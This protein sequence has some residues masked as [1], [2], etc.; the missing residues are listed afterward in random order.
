MSKKKHWAMQKPVFVR[1][2]IKV[3]F[4]T[5]MLAEVILSVAIGINI[6]KR[7]TEM[8]AALTSAINESAK[9]AGIFGSTVYHNTHYGYVPSK[10]Y[11]EYKNAVGYYALNSDYATAIVEPKGNAGNPKI[12][13]DNF[14]PEVFY[15]YF[16]GSN[17]NN[18]FSVSCYRLYDDDP[19][20]LEFLNRTKGN[21]NMQCQLV[22]ESLHVFE[23][24][25]KFVPKSV[26]WLN[27]ET[28]D[29][30]A[31]YTRK[32]EIPPGYKEV[33]N[34][35]ITEI[36]M[37][38]PLNYTHEK[39]GKWYESI[40]E[41]W[42]EIQARYG[43]DAAKQLQEDIQNG[44]I[45]NRVISNG[46]L[47]LRYCAQAEDIVLVDKHGEQHE[48]RII[49][50]MQYN[51]WEIYEKS[52]VDTFVYCMMPIL[53]VSLAAAYIVYLKKW[54]LWQKNAFSRTLTNAVA[55]DLKTPLM[56]ISTMVDNLK[57]CV[58][59]EEPK[60]YTE[61][62]SDTVGYMN[63]MIEDILDLN[64]IEG[65]RPILRLEQVRLE[66][67]LAE[68]VESVQSVIREKQLSIAIQGTGLCAGDYGLLRQAFGNLV[69][70]AV[71]YTPKGGFVTIDISEHKVKI[72]NTGVSLTKNF[73]KKAFDPFMKADAARS[74][75][76]GSGVGLTIARN[77]FD[78][79]GMKCR[80]TG[81]A[82]SVT[83]TVSL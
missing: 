68:V 21:P 17:G 14:S 34:R 75:R 35:Y 65:N 79:H 11:C 7:H 9:Y 78:A 10:I 22:A 58:E 23:P 33:P 53:V 76:S 43:G 30:L 49:R 66:K 80:M 27:K 6:E 82:Q 16:N 28:G 37:E 26:Q 51:L 57:E 83:V 61:E 8:R 12:I 60:Y 20:L 42:E 56:V 77:I 44:Y 29:I 69:D 48:Y 52:I 32:L 50:A 5:F 38:V 4:I 72:T 62:V 63:K 18:Y 45:G 24:T 47:G 41:D 64:R 54:N 71:K 59:G 40:E 73:M 1:I 67:V 31:T 3:F 74:N 81:D 70:N 19:E 2:F 13:M 25:K 39:T 46:I 36:M 15:T 55:H